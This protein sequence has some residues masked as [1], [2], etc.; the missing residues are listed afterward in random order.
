LKYN[1]LPVIVY[2]YPKYSTQL[3]MNS[4]LSQNTYQLSKLGSFNELSTYAIQHPNPIFTTE[5]KK[6]KH[7]TPYL[8]IH[9]PD[10][11]WHGEMLSTSSRHFTIFENTWEKRVEDYFGNI[12]KAVV[13]PCAVHETNTCTRE[14][15]FYQLSPVWEH[16]EW[17]PCNEVEYILWTIVGIKCRAKRAIY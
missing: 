3:K 13:G 17:Q 6:S 15:Y 4:V 10:M 5:L 2:I 12:G 8:M 7:R 9:I 16:L 14:R 11:G 1:C